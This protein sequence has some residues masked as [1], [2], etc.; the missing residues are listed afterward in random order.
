MSYK[1]DITFKIRW[2]NKKKL[3]E[4]KKVNIKY[5]YNIIKIFFI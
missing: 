5:L 3:Y 2:N 4:N 1:E